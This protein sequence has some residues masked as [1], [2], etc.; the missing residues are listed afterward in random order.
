MKNVFAFALF[1]AAL[2]MLSGCFLTKAPDVEIRRLGPPANVNLVPG[3]LDVGVPDLADENES[4]ATGIVVMDLAKADESDKWAYWK[5]GSIAM[6]YRASPE[7]VASAGW[8]MRLTKYFPIVGSNGGD[9]AQDEG[10]P[11]GRALF[12]VVPDEWGGFI[13]R[14]VSEIVN[15]SF[16]AD[17]YEALEYEGVKLQPEY[18]NSL[19]NNIG[20]GLLKSYSMK[21]HSVELSQRIFILR[22]ADGASYYAIRFYFYS[23]ADK[24]IAFQWKKLI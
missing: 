10:S 9:T 1:A 11:D 13:P 24:I 3:P 22:T 6:R 7:F 18:Q 5:A 14:R 8:D 2:P 16:V 23:R 4:V 21:D 19:V 20:K 12:A 15:L 17:K